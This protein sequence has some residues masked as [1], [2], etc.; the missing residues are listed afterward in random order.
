MYALLADGLRRTRLQSPDWQGDWNAVHHA[1]AR[2]WLSR[3]IN[4]ETLFDAIYIDPMFSAPRRKARPQRAL[5]WM[6]ELIGPDEDAAELLEVARQ[7][8]RRVVV[9]CHAR[10][11]PLADP[12]HQVTGKAMR[13]DVY[14]NA[15]SDFR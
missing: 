8:A 9:K 1:D 6:N 4:A 7:N 10:A 14:F 12:D 2:T 15:S 13:F 3:Q 5:Q 11:A